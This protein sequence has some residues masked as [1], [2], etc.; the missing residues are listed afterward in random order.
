MNFIQLIATLFLT[1]TLT[2]C[3]NINNKKSNDFNLI[4]TKYTTDNSTTKNHLEIVITSKK[5]T[6]IDFQKIYFQHTIAK[7]SIKYH[8]QQN[9][10]TI[11]AYYQ[12]K[13]H[14]I[15]ENLSLNANPEK[16]YGNKIT[17]NKTKFPYQLKENQAIIE[18]KI[19]NKTYF[20]K[21][22]NIRLQEK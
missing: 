15:I 21:V 13:S 20:Y 2:K 5:N 17:Q 12:K 14:K 7:P 22:T 18:Y 16:E 11:N 19:K 4:S 8:Q 10:Q 3:A 9:K 6:T 1:L